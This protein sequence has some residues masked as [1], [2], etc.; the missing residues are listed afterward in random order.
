MRWKRL[1]KNYLQGKYS[2]RSNT[3]RKGED[4]DEDILYEK[5]LE[6]RIDTEGEEMLE[7]SK[8]ERNVLYLELV[9]VRGKMP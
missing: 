3:T 2:K 6:K 8:I 7:E 1:W 4:I 9:Y 5:L